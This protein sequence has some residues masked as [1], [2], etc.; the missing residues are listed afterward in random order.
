MHVLQHASSPSTVYTTTPIQARDSRKPDS[1]VSA[2]ERADRHSRQAPKNACLDEAATRT[3][4]EAGQRCIFT[5]IT[6][7]VL[8]RFTTTM[9]C[10]DDVDVDRHVSADNSNDHMHNTGHETRAS[11]R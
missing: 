5:S 2:V 3:A 4:V 11:E 9:Q 10:K 8:M 7:L 1:T 6:R